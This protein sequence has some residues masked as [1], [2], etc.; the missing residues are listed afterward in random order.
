[1][2]LYGEKKTEA[3]P[4]HP[5]FVERMMKGDVR[6]TDETFDQTAAELK[7]NND[8]GS[9]S[10]LIKDWMSLLPDSG[11][12]RYYKSILLR[13]SRSAKATE[14]ME[15]A[16]LSTKPTISKRKDELESAWLWLCTQLYREGY[17]V[18]SAWCGETQL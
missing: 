4:S 7:A 12:A 9:I 2:A 6:V 13:Q 11:N 5:G 10:N 15:D 16:F 1:M 17:A 3:F 14:M 8:F 18:E